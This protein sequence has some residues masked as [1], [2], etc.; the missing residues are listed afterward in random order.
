[1]HGKLFKEKFV[2]C[3]AITVQQ[4]K[5]LKATENGMQ[6]YQGCYDHVSLRKHPKAKD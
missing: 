5:D 6:N 4:D 2:R 3:R 1:M